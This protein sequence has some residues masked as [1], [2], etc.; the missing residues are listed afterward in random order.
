MIAWFARNDVAANLLMMAIFLVGAYMLTQEIPIE[1]F[2]TS[3]VDTVSVNVS[4]PGASP[5]EIEEG[6]SIRIEEAVQDLNGIKRI[7]SRSR[8][9]R[10]NVRIEGVDGVD[11]RELM[12]DIKVRVD[13]I[14]GFPEDAER[15]VVDFS[16]WQRDV[17][18][19]VVYGK[20]D[21]KILRQIGENI[22][23]NIA[24]MPGITK[25]TL[26]FVKRYEMSIEVS[27]AKLREYHL[28]LAEVA[29]RLRESSFDLSAGSVRTSG[30]EIFLRSRGQAYVASDYAKIPVITTRSGEQVLLGDI[31][32]IRDGFEEIHRSM[33]FNGQD[34]VE[35]EVFRVGKQS[36]IEI[37]EKV[38]A[39]VNEKQQ[40]LPE[41]INIGIWRDRS[42][43]IKARFQTL[44]YSALQSAIL[45]CILL[46]LFLR[47][48][49]AFWVCVGVPIS[50]MG[51]F[52]LMPFLD[53]SLNLISVFAFILVLGIVVDDAI[54]TGENIYSHLQK[55]EAP[56]HAAV[57]GTKE[58][59]VPVTFG[60]LT[61]MAAF[62]PLILA[63]G[64]L[65]WYSA[66]PAVVIS[67]LLFS[68]IESKLILP[69][70]LKNIH[71]DTNKKTSGLTA[72]QRSI[73]QSMETFIKQ[74]Y[75]P[76]LDK[77][78]YYRYT[79]FS[80]MVSLLVIVL[81][82][83]MHTHWIKFIGFPRV[84]SE[85][86]SA[87]VTMPVGTPI[88]RTESTVNYVI[89]K[90]QE[91][92]NRYKEPESGKSVIK[93]IFSTMG[94]DDGRTGR[95]NFEVIPPE[96]RESE[97]TTKELIQEW[98]KSVGTLAG[99]ESLHFRGE[100]GR[101]GEP[102][103]IQLMGRDIRQLEGLTKDIKSKLSEYS[104]VFDIEDSL[105]DGKEELLL[106]LKPEATL[107]G[108]T[109][110]DLARQVRQAIHGLEVQ[111]IQ[112]GRDEIRIM[113]RY[114]LA[115]RKSLGIFDSMLI[116]SE[117]GVE[118]PFYDVA[119]IQPGR[120]PSTI[121]RVDR[122]RTI[123]VT[124]DFDKKNGNLSRVR[125]EMGVYVQQ[126]IQQHSNVQF[127]F[128]G[129][130]R[131]EKEAKESLYFGGVLLAFLIFVL[132]AIP[133][134]SYVQPFIV[135]SVIPFGL[136]GAVIGHMVMGLNLTILSLMGLLALSGVVV[137]DSLV[138]VDYINQ[139]RKE[140]VAIYDAVL[141]AGV[142]RFRPVIL[143]SLT[144]FIGMMP[145]L[146]EK[147]TQGQF[148]VHMAVSLGFGIL[149]ATII[150]LLLIPANYLILYDIKSLASRFERFILGN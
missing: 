59:A 49:V 137:N 67:V 105:N 51:A 17:I 25:V 37:A 115:H 126:L 11:I 88:E 98:R 128:Q 21:E 150:T 36:A 34:A 127:S 6:I 101:R 85:I 73:A 100:I 87:R 19:V 38:K 52:I 61:T 116:R 122:N 35:I 56:Y 108:L 83:L 97:V 32:E 65:T 95:V 99:V 39:Y 28:T 140:G 149:F 4:L 141:Q 110:S 48:A 113:L 94:S 139:R 76:F 57:K 69:A 14:N 3:E 114:P 71:V 81:V 55:G 45:V 26:D 16:R 117:G 50:F 5:R 103:D 29:N 41:N 135:M 96:Q 15:P 30:G 74:V 86:A 125:D 47:P 80:F 134:K 1:L 89:A 133:F 53:V 109:S 62:L 78:L 10:A 68:L 142:A 131:D 40:T 33:R 130:A 24:N 129:D 79:T 44:Q 58:I 104:A 77:A 54:V 132:L 118:V 23:E 143:T 111:R 2:P 27:E 84:P 93:N 8:E 70:H 7:V 18:S 106:V 13:A 107:I 46:A 66:L 92:Q 136:V 72:L 120:S 148:L 102:I 138:L 63:E 145:L 147:S 119:D 112:R 43:S 42:N 31:A 121:T 124:A 12:A 82:M 75:A 22:R 9:G 91:L 64:R 144:T 60:V 90:A 20:E 146:L 123:N